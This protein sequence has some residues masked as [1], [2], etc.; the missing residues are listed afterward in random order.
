M[1]FS[2]LIVTPP[3]YIHS[4]CFEEVAQSL[5]EAL[6]A[7][8]HES[9]IATLP[10]PSADK[11][12]IL[13]GHLLHPADM[14]GIPYPIIYQL[15]Q[16]PDKSTLAYR[17]VMS[18]ASEVWD[19]SL[20]N[21][22]NL[23][24]A[25]HLAIGYSPCLT[26]IPKSNEDIDVLHIGSMN[27][28]R[29]KILRELRS[30]GLNVVHAFNCYGNERDELIS[31]AKI[32][33]NIH[34]YEAKIFEI[35]RC[36]YLMA[37]QKAIVSETGLDGDLEDPY[38]DGISFADYNSLVDRCLAFLSDEKERLKLERKGFDIFSKRL[39]VD[40]LRGVL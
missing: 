37:N 18:L 26:K 4:R 21:I 23:P 31:R 22:Q 29:D 17:Q 5:N 39:Q 12:I 19:Y 27:H 28:R 16:M 24:G 1:K 38:N 2:V 34:Y 25:K 3:N 8:G 20:L 40:F 33:I 36:S 13:G 35:V 14:K 6:I 30:H 10:A 32:V 7:L 11:T 15:E 9:C